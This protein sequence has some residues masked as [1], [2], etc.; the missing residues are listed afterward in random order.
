MNNIQEAPGSEA[1]VVPRGRAPDHPA[2]PPELPPDK[3][4]R[5]GRRL[6]AGGTFV[7]LCAAL[8][9][10]FWQHY[11]LHAEVLATAEQRRD[12]VPSVRT[13]AVRVSGATITVNWP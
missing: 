5:T 7:L 9:I 2:T 6:L 12:F 11:K 8:G 1:G 10:G 3:P 13:A 4:M